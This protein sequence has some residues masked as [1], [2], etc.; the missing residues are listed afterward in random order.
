VYQTTPNT[1]TNNS[2][3]YAVLDTIVYNTAGVT[4][5]ATTGKVTPRQGS[6]AVTAR[7][8]DY[9]SGAHVGTVRVTIYKNDVA[10]L[11]NFRN[12][13]S[14]NAGSFYDGTSQDEFVVQCSGSDYL[15]VGVYVSTDGAASGVY[16]QMVLHR[17][18]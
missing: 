8:L 5:D 1:L 13:F 16:A 14:N 9:T 3:A 10:I 4:L 17:I 12:G 15:H 11:A 18:V 7:A 2:W 6:Y